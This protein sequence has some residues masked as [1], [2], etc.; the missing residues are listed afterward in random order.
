[1][2][3][4]KLLL[5]FRHGAQKSGHSDHPLQSYGQI[6]FNIFRYILQKFFCSGLLSA[7]SKS[8]IFSFV[9][10]IGLLV[11]LILNDSQLWNPLKKMFL[12]ENLI[13]RYLG[14]PLVILVNKSLKAMC[15][16]F[17]IVYQHLF[18]LLSLWTY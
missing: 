5:D 10:C 9:I 3:E 14:F 17:K 4:K 16:S 11:A 13:F 18:Y 8:K 12:S 6:Y 1:M 2:S 7:R 15:L